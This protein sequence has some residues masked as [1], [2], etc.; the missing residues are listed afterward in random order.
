MD[1]PQQ[2]ENSHQLANSDQPVNHAGHELTD[3]DPRMIGFFGLGLALMVALTLPLLSWTYWHWEADAVRHDG[4]APTA[5][6]AR[7]PQLEVDA[8]AELRRLRDAESATLSNY[9]W[10]DKQR[11]IVRIPVD[12]A[13][14]LL[15]ERGFLEASTPPKL[16][17]QDKAP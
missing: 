9:G 4:P 7:Q 3:A 15:A 16:N 10:V 6:P 11:K 17:P 8:A 13:A 2:P 12:R 14:D 1:T 5:R